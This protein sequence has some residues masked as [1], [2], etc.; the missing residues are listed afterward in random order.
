MPHVIAGRSIFDETKDLQ[1][2]NS[3]LTRGMLDGMYVSIRPRPAVSDKV[4]LDSLLDWV[5]GA[6]IRFAQGAK[7]GDGHILWEKP[8]SVLPD[9]LAALEYFNTVQ[10]KRVGTNRMSNQGMDADSLNKTFGG[11]KLSFSASSQRQKLIART[12]AETFLVR[13]YRLIYRAIKRAATGEIS[14]WAGDGFKKADPT[15]WPD[16][17]DLTVD[18][19]LGTGNTEQELGHLTVLAN[20]Q[21]KLVQLQGGTAGPFVKPD[22]VANLSQKFSEKLGFKTPGI[23][24]QPPEKVEEETAKRAQQEA[25]NGPQVPPEVQAEQAKTAGAIEVQKAQ[26]AGDLQQLQ[27]EQAVNAQKAQGDAAIKQMELAA[28]QEMDARQAQLHME[29]MRLK[30]EEI[31]LKRLELAAKREQMVRDS[32]NAARDQEHEVVG[33]RHER[34]MARMKGG[35]SDVDAM[36][37]MEDGGKGLAGALHASVQASQSHSQM[38]AE[39]LQRGLQSVGEGLAKMA[40][41]VGAESEITLSSGKTVRSRKVPRSP[42]P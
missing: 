25:I 4:I 42:T 24:F 33:Q 19:G 28:K 27:A 5:P 34:M 39:A 14:Y 3:A 41:A 2:I 32:E 26:L 6:P 18:V 37:D 7:P 20:V 30:Q 35:D 36:S 21:E 11:A 38:L 12:F 40:D 16:D 10:E 22:N 23:F 29:E 31:D 13:A 8:P 17:M 1:Q 15:K 9:A